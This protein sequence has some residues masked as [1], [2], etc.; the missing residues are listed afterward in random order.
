MSKGY[1]STNLA[2]MSYDEAYE[3]LLNADFNAYLRSKNDP[4]EKENQ[5][6]EALGIALQLLQEKTAQGLNSLLYRKMFDSQESFKTRM[7]SM[8]RNEVD[9]LTYE[10]AK[11][12]DILLSLEYYDMSGAE[13]QAL[14]DTDD[15][16]DEVFQQ[17]EQGA[18]GGFRTDVDRAWNAVIRC[19]ERLLSEKEAKL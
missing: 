1:E 16:L 18:V 4:G 11:R 2:G 5:F 8:G 12:N 13:A 19:A 17:Y 15:P 9:S 10:Y 7:L 3:V 14:L 6:K